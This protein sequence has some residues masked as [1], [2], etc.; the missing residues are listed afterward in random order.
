MLN[1]TE[2]KLTV[3]SH[4]TGMEIT[5]RVTNLVHV[6]VLLEDRGPH[7]KPSYV[8]TLAL[9]ILS[10]LEVSLINREPAV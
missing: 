3:L 10:M 8:K 5:E 1:L 9:T 6:G 2:Y 4:L 7:C